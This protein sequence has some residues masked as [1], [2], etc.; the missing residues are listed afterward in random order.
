MSGV[1]PARASRPR[2]FAARSHPSSSA[3]GAPPPGRWRPGAPAPPS[4]GSCGVHERRVVEGAHRGIDARVDR[5]RLLQV[6]SLDA[7]R[8]NATC[9]SA[10]TLPAPE[11]QAVGTRAPGRRVARRCGVVSG[12]RTGRSRLF[13]SRIW[14]S[15]WLPSPIWSLTAR[16]VG[17]RRQSSISACRGRS[18]IGRHRVL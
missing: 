14:R 18:R 9:R 1:M 13:S 7:A 15:C 5:L 16:I 6:S 12:V 10:M 8:N 3:A 11:K 2:I 17:K 4:C